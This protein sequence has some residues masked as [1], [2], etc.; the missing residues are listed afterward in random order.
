MCTAVIRWRP[1]APLCLLALRDEY[2][3]RAFDDPDVWWHEQP[4]VVGGRDRQAGGSWCVTDVATGR[5]ALV[6]NR[7]Q[8]RVADPEAPSRG[9]L[10]L[11]AVRHGPEWPR[12]VPLHGMASFVV[13]LASQQ[14]LTLWEFD[15]SELTSGWLAEGTHMITSGGSE[16]RKA[17]RHLATFESS[18]CDQW[19]DLVARFPIQDDTASLLVRQE[20]EGRVYGTVFGQMI[21]AAAGRLTVTWSRSPWESASWTELSWSTG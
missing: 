13:V 19:R 15:G 10:P 18:D 3:G 6:L 14:D 17:D 5:T 8:R 7:P 16:D 2:T 21:R 4:H 11:L 12:H 1:G 9:L 20:R